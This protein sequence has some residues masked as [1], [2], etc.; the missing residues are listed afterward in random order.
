MKVYT[1][2]GIL[3]CI[4]MKRGVKQGDALLI[5]LLNAMLNDAVEALV[6]TL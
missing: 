1:D 4:D 5:V 2:K 3:N 6:E